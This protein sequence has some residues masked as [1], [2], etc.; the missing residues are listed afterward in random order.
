MVCKIWQALDFIQIFQRGITPEME[1]TQTRNKTCINY[2]SMRNP[3]MK[4]QNPSM[5]GFWRMARQPE[6][7]MLPQLL[8]KHLCWGVYSFRLSICMFVRASV[9]NF[10][11]FVELSAQWRLWSD[12]ADALYTVCNS[13]CI[14][15]SH[16]S[17]E[18]PH[19]LNFRIITAFFWVSE[20]LVAL[21]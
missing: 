14:F 5:H 15:W 9:R 11:L 10:F 19:C 4:F 12:W 17:M 13:V 20:Y 3:Y 1:I 16:Y 2:F 6:T 7:N 18:E 21:W 8:R